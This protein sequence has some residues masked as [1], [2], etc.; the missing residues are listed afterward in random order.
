MP[1]HAVTAHPELQSLSEAGGNAH[2]CAARVHQDVLQRHWAGVAKVP[3]FLAQQ[4]P[5]AVPGQAGWR[6][7]WG[8]K[9]RDG[10]AVRIVAAAA[11]RERV[12][13]VVHAAVAGM[14]L[15]HQTRLP[16]GD[17][18]VAGITVKSVLGAANAEANR[19]SDLLALIIP[20]RATVTP[21][22]P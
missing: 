11:P 4:A 18:A 3:S 15:P 20:L 10:C 9:T 7:Q 13:R 8:E 5:V 21:I 19:R 6:V 12:V 14:L 22:A 16:I 1:L 17:R 2:C